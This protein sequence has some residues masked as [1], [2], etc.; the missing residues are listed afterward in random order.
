MVVPQRYS[1]EYVRLS[2]L[3]VTNIN[4]LTDCTKVLPPAVTSFSASDKCQV[5]QWAKT[6]KSAPAVAQAMAAGQ[7]I[8]NLTIPRPS[9]SR[10]H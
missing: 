10:K 5:Q 2:L 9:K 4:N 3:G 1:R 8:N 7:L 6:D